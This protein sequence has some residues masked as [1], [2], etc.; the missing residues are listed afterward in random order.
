VVGAASAWSDAEIITPAQ[1]AVVKEV[2]ALVAAATAVVRASAVA[3]EEAEQAVS[4]AR[5]HYGVR[6]VILGRR[7]MGVSD[8]LLNGPAE[9]SR[10]TVVYKQVFR[11]EQANEIA[12]AKIRKEPELVEMLL[13]RYD[14]VESFE[15]KDAAGQL[16]GEAL[17]MSKETRS[18]LVDAEM[19]RS[20]AVDAEATARM[21]L[22]MQLEQA[23]GKLRAAFPGKRDFVESFF[24]KR[25][26]AS[27]KN[28]S[29]AAGPTATCE[30]PKAG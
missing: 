5:A 15:G 3:T 26:R 13:A 2:G 7:V 4:V 17:K 22:R 12:G 19:A 24:P 25:E 1:K 6:D 18:T 29:V 27:K 11:N 14:A 20:K 30:S 16:L 23:Y 10:D 9:R 21:V 28:V 8:A